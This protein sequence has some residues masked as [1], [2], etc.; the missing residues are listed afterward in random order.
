M[1][2][3][4]YDPTKYIHMYMYTYIF[5]SSVNVNMHIYISKTIRGKTNKSGDNVSYYCTQPKFV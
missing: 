4:I 1:K 2:G 3:D 5:L